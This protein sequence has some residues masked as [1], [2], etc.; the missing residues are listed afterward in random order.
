[1]RKH[2]RRPL[3]FLYCTFNSLATSRNSFISIYRSYSV[4]GILSSS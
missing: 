3:P 4:Y 2:L 1:M